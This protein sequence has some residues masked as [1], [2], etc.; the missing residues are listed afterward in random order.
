V[1]AEKRLRQWILIMDDCKDV[2]SRSTSH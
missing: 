1:R 2:M